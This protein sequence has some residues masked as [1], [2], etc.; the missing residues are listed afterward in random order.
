MTLS[1]EDKL[2]IHELLARVAYGYDERD[3]E[4]LESGFVPQASM[5]L[6]VAGGDPVGPFEGRDNIMTLFRDSMSTQ[7]DVRRHDVTNIFFRD[8]EEGLEV[9]SNLTL[10]ATENGITRLLTTGVYQDLIEKT[11]QGWQIRRRHLD[12]DSAY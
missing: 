8:S 3:L 9:V 4:M 2:Q 12:L 6:R 5:S 7:T 1:D 11:P 10:F